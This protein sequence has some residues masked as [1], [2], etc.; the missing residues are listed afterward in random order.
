MESAFLERGIRLIRIGA[1]T[2]REPLIPTFSRGE[3]VS[4]AFG[5]RHAVN[6]SQRGK[7]ASPS[8]RES[9][10]VRGKCRPI[11]QLPLQSQ[12]KTAP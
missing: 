7:Y 3:K 4:Y 5:S 2:R 6:S 1:I 8:P 12:K 10:R 9:D 11:E